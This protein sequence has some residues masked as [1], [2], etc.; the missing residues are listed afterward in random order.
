MHPRR[1]TARDKSRP[2]EADPAQV[3]WIPVYR[4]GGLAD[5]EEISLLDI[6][7]ILVRYKFTV[8]GF[9]ALAGLLAC[10]AA[11]LMTPQ[12]RTEVLLAPVSDVNESDRYATQFQEFGSIAALAGIK[13]D[14]KDRKAES[15]A[16][17]RSRK[18]TDQFIQDRKLDRVLFAKLWDDEHQRWKSD[19]DIPT[20]W[21]AFEL[22]DE[23][24]RRIREDKGTG[25]VTL[26]IEWKDPGLAAQWANELVSSVNT[27]LRQ[28][29]VD[30]SNRAIEYLQD[31]LSRTSVVELQQVLHRVIESEMKDIILANLNEEYAFKVIDPAVVPEE[32]ARPKVLVMVVLGT[33]FGLILGV[34]VA[35][36][37]NARQAGHKLSLP[38]PPA[39]GAPD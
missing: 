19:E 10:A 29:S 8:L 37:L 23:K 33:V 2:F 22:F 35:L 32:P 15:L 21:D 28:Q 20:A 7:R 25:L 31:Q 36:V 3:E 39:G 18:F 27:T 17:L 38:E 1:E 26:S 24:I 9:A 12:Y 13:L 16:T 30:D 5:D 34:V 11:L 6:W 14:H 4:A